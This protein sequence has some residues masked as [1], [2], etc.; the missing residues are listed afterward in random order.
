MS[1]IVTR[2]S[3][4]KGGLAAVALPSFAGTQE[5]PE[6]KVGVISDIHL[7]RSKVRAE[8]ICLPALEW[9]RDQGVDAVV[10]TGDLATTG[11][12]AELEL[13]SY[14]WYKTFPDDKLPDGRHVEK[15]FLYGNH[16]TSPDVEIYSIREG[17]QD[18]FK[19]ASVLTDRAKAWET[20]FHEKFEPIYTKRVK[21]YA[22]VA[23]HWNG[24]KESVPGAPEYLRA[25]A[26]DLAGDKPFFYCQHAPLLGTVNP[27]LGHFDD[28]AVTEVLKGFPNAIAFTGHSH[29]S[30]T[31]ETSIWQGAFTA[32]CGSCC[33][34]SGMRYMKPWFENSDVPGTLDVPYK[35]RTDSQM[36]ILNIFNGGQGMLVEVFKDRVVFHRKSF[37]YNEP[38]GADWVVPLPAG[39][40]RPY[41]IDARREASSSP[42][43]SPG[44]KIEVAERDGANRAKVPMRQLVVSFPAADRG[45][46]PFGYEVTVASSEAGVEPVVRC[47]LSPDFH[48]PPTRRVKSAECVFALDGLPPAGLR[49][50]SVRAFNSFRRYGK[51][52]CA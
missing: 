47:V 49:R 12:L 34:G 22:F 39:K 44:A 46:R 29:A 31:D 4:I 11:M 41:E 10:C 40:S 32:V 3:F 52:I 45:D 17:R 2:A 16:D 36:P 21:G 51:A 5:K 13:L 33:A 20:C 48:L 50:I 24:L 23:A 26:A 37:V 7:T 14:V 38:N 43:F 42:E 25:H 6:L 28:G 15:V 30:L 18:E 9:F 27:L 8:R 19:R 1:P 35:K